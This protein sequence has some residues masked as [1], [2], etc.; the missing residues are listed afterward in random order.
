MPRTQQTT[1]SQ[2][3][4][5]LLVLAALA[6][7]IL[8]VFAVSGDLRVP[9]I[10]KTYTVRTRMASVDGLT[11]GAEVRLSGKRIGS[12]KNIKFGD[13]PNEP[14]SQTNILIE[15]EIDGKL[16][17]QPAIERIRTDSLAILKSAGVLGDNV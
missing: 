5:G 16:D 11:K 6:I 1:L 3:R 4:V 9:G 15:M 13:I 7:L 8:T 14:N 2:M 12:V 10:T 17:G